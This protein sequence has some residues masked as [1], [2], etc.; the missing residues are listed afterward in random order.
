MHSME[1]N[2]SYPDQT[3]PEE[4][5]DLG[6][7][8]L[9]YRLTKYKAFKSVHDNCHDWREKVDNCHDWQEKG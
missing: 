2:T 3:S 7:Y 6:Y 1:A 4:Q 5:S 9:K 8:C